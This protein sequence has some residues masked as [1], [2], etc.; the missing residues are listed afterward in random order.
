MPDNV[1]D[2]DGVSRSLTERLWS[3]DGWQ[4]LRV[5]R[6]EI[7]IPLGDG[8]M[9]R[10]F[11]AEDVLLRRQ[12]A[13]K[14]ISKSVREAHQSGH[15]EQFLREAQAVAAL[16]HPHVARIYDIV[17]QE[18]VV[19][20]AT[21]YVS[22][23]TFEDFIRHTKEPDILEVCRIVAETAAGLQCAHEHGMIHRDVKPANLML[24]P[25]KKCK[26]VDFGASRV[27]R[28]KELSILDGKIIGTP[29]TIS[30]EVI[31]G[32][33]PRP[34]SD[35]Y[36][37]GIVLWWALT[38]H[39]PFYAKTK[40]QLYRKHLEDSAPDITTYRPDVPVSLAKI[41]HRCL[42]KDPRKRFSACSEIVERLGGVMK[43]LSTEYE[44]EISSL[45]V[46]LSE[47]ADSKQTP[48]DTGAGA[49]T[50]EGFSTVAKK[51]T[52][53]AGRTS[54]T[55]IAATSVTQSRQKMYYRLIAA[56]LIFVIAAV[57]V[58]VTILLSMPSGGTDSKAKQDPVYIHARGPET[59]TPEEGP[60]PAIDDT[61]SPDE[62]SVKDS[63]G[64][65]STD[66]K[67]P[68][69]AGDGLFDM[70][71]GGEVI[72][73]GDE[74]FAILENKH[75]I[76]SRGI[77]KAVDAELH[78]EGVKYEV[79]GPRNSERNCIGCWSN[80]NAWVSWKVEFRKP[81][82]YQVE[83]MQAH[84]QRGGNRYAV[85]VCGQEL[86]GTVKKTGG[87]DQFVP[88]KLGRIAVEKAGTYQV[89]V[90]P[91]EKITGAGMMNLRAVTFTR[92]K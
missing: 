11:L 1:S 57:A 60:G 64:G 56:I 62:T 33:E 73:L 38:G 55:V 45:S 81:G 31:R 77:L 71:T 85:T 82:E 53:G 65:G 5:G 13:L 69:P 34:E 67:P 26:I 16:S 68:P 76:G 54:R 90:K 20:I 79:K 42:K 10:V 75:I 36:S 19:A 78:G 39:P 25:K 91:V 86:K 80:V 21:E 28:K 47:L 63:T 49:R 74:A 2:N 12:V 22:G 51:S 35:I 29:Y 40:K 92:M 72:E 61:P 32:D 24:T 43:D 70:G 18:G 4:D 17:Q 37:L 50:G 66:D 46:V 83:I 48:G 27:K 58:A 7:K 3:D 9:G 23:G 30:P 59:G 44:G 88:V 52:P 84:Q 8:G 89:S 41:V 14:V 6:Y 15:L 87:W